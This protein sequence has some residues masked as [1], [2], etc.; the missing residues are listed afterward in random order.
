MSIKR[1]LTSSL[2]SILNH[3]TPSSASELS[4]KTSFQK[5]ACAAIWTW[6]FVPHTFTILLNKFAG[7]IITH[8]RWS[9]ITSRIRRF[10]IHWRFKRHR[11]RGSQI[12]ILSKWTSASRRRSKILMSGW[13]FHRRRSKILMSGWS[14]HWRRS[15]IFIQL[16]L[17]SS[18]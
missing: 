12:K 8:K 11:R 1:L 13:S 9:S 17:C 2:T 7:W 15:I 6:R 14:F 16:L 18:K 3:A 10:I 4:R 5:T